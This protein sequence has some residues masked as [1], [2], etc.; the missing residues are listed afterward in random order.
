MRLS[1]CSCYLYVDQPFHDVTL[2]QILHGRG[3]NYFGNSDTTSHSII[4]RCGLK[5][6]VSSNGLLIKLCR[7]KLGSPVIMNHRVVEAAAAEFLFNIF[8]FVKVVSMYAVEVTDAGSPVSMGQWVK[9]LPENS[10]T[11]AWMVCLDEGLTFVEYCNLLYKEWHRYMTCFFCVGG[12]VLGS[13][14]TVTVTIARTGYANGKF[15]FRGSST[16][17]VRRSTSARTVALM[18]ERTEGLQGNQIVSVETAVL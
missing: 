10:L 11:V 15:G 17:R 18:I 7:W 9:S 1:D 13:R 3:R 6:F 16:L 4:S 5:S 12:A 2:M 8:S 14:T